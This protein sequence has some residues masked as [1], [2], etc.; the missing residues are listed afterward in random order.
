MG[1]QAEKNKIERKIRIVKTATLCVLLAALL[2][3]C[4]FSAFV[5]PDTWKYHVGKPDIARRKDG[6]LRIHFLDV[7]QG[8]ATLLE[9]P[10]GKTVLIDGGDDRESTE[11]AILRYMNA[12]EIDTIDHLVVTHADGDH[13]GSLDRILQC[14]EVLNAYLPAVK[15]ENAS[16][17][18]AGFYAQL[19]EETCTRQFSSRAISLGN[20]GGEYPYELSFLYPYT[21]ETNEEAA[22]G[23]AYADDNEL[24]SV[25]WLDYRGVSALFT[26]DAP[27]ATENV[28]MRDDGMGLFENRGVRLQSTEILKVSHHGSADATSLRFLQYLGVETAVISCGKNNLYGHPTLTVRENL[29]SAGVTAYRTD[30]Q[31][32]VVITITNAGKYAVTSVA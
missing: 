19:L 4:I 13:C 11:T 32:T 1:Y 22:E 20:S 17:T 12:L 5:P 30:E 23:N 6:E 10:D 16:A 24:S 18:Y 9:L 3:L 21:S 15:P 2:G 25:L 8:D 7:G 28:L 27:L 29:K 26:G 31:G 14:K